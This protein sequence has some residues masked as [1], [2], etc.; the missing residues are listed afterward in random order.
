MTEKLKKTIISEYLK[1]KGSTTLVKELKLS[2][3]TILKILN[4]AGVIRKRDRCKSLDIELLD[5]KYV[6]YRNCPTCKERLIV[7]TTNHSITCRN[8]FNSL[9]QNCKKCSLELQK[10]E[11]NPF[12]GKKHNKNSLE[13]ISKSRKGK[14]CGE[15]NSMAN[16]KHRKKSGDKIREKWKNGEMEHARKIMSNTLKTMRKTGKIK[17][18]IVSKKEKEIVGEIRKMGYKVIPSFRI[19]SKVCDVYVPELNLIIEYNGDYWHCNP[20]KYCSDYYHQVKKKTA[21]EMW[22][23]DEKK[24]DLI[25]KYGYNLEVVWETE[26]KNDNK[27][28]NHIIQ[29]YVKTK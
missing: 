7:S 19:E 29:K 27:K 2:K 11:G 22:D 13:K 26:L 25:K 17:S 9:E 1:G 14:G 20:I 24:V 8:Y 12:Y 16:P 5:D 6:T 10:G 15:N 4:D 28:I 21:K 23:Y 3:P 18:V